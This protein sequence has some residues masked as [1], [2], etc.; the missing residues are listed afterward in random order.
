MSYVFLGNRYFFMVFH[1]MNVNQPQRPVHCKT[2][3]Q[4][5]HEYGIK[6]GNLP[7]YTMEKAEGEAHQPSFIFNVKIEDVCC[8]GWWYL[9]SEQC[10]V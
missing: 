4:I 8:S 2:P 1:S 6:T 10:T 5:L 9:S 3:I 7:V